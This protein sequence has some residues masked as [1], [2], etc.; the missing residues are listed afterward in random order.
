MDIKVEGRLCRIGHIDGDSY[1]FLDDPERFL[2][3]LRRSGQPN[4]AAIGTNASSS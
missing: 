2:D 3:E 1:K 4:C